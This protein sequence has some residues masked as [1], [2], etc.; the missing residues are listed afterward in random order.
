MAPPLD[1]GLPTAL[2]LIDNQLAFCHPSTVSHWGSSRSNPL[3]E[4]NLQ[5]LLSAARDR[6]S[7]AASNPV[8]VIHVF[9]SSTTP[10]SP[11]HPSHPAQ[12]IRPLEFATPAADGSEPVFWKS[13]NS[14]FIGT[15]L[16]AHLQDKGIRQLLFAGLTTDHCVST[17]VR[18]AANL[19]VVDGSVDNNAETLGPEGANQGRVERGR[20]V[21]VADATAT[22]AKGGYDAETVHHVS[23]ASL[24]GEFAD[25][26]GTE[27]VVR[28]LRGV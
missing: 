15:D 11:L 6:A 9:H 12:G 24:E 25:I 13:V 1:L 2:I 20:I 26:L 28:A 4:G 8:E 10:G 14:S 22:F 23:V 21:L 17:T 5:S 19:G 16:A 3:Y 27:A 18:M 7:L